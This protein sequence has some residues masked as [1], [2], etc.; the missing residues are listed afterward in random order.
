M[1][2][3]VVLSVEEGSAA[4]EGGIEAGD[5][6][7]RVNGKK[8][9]DI[10]DYKFYTSDE[11]VE[12]VFMDKDSNEYVVQI[13]KDMYE[14]I[15]IDFE[16]SL[17]DDD[18]RCSNKCIFCFID[19]L[20]EGMRETVYFKDDDTRLSFLTGNYVT[21]TNVNKKELERI[22]KYK[23]SPV[24]VS[25]QTTNPKL[26]SFMLGNKK[27]ADIMDKLKILC[28]GGIDVN[29]QIVLCP[30]INDGQELENTMKDLIPLSY[31][32][33]SVSIVPVGLT[34]YRSE[35]YKLRLFTKTECVDVIKYIG[36]LQKKLKKELGTSFIYAADEFY[37]KAEIEM[38]DYES[39][40]DFPQLENGVGMVRSLEY[41]VKE[42]LNE[43]KKTLKKALV[44]KNISIA[45]GTA[46][47][48]IIE[49][50]VSMI[51]TYVPKLSVAIYSIT[52]N[53]FGDTVTVSGLLTGSDL[54]D[55]LKDKNLGK[56]LLI[57]NNMLRRGENVFLDDMTLEQLQHSLGVSICPVLDSG[58]DFVEK[59]LRGG[60]SVE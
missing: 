58:K 9:K 11:Y 42:Y 10:F 60:M 59:I 16:N 37:L 47:Y 15:G 38:P 12:L 32:I 21:L 40:E 7:L 25:V 13:E 44:N 6:L 36:I 23:L 49:K 35:L 46:S 24:N 57:S 26:R 2:K 22:V 17:L 3:A 31:G 50:L 55:Q 28:D 39:Y 1:S 20:P 48:G 53:Y 34:K 8:I 43:N 33:K 51:L 54:K 5:I 27:A 45:T 29:C 19:Q 4:F 14:D 30:G 52:N 56:A 18:K 41:E